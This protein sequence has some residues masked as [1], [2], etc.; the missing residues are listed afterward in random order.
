MTADFTLYLDGSTILLRPENATA[1]KHVEE[2]VAEYG[3]WLVRFYVKDGSS[4]LLRKE[5]EDAFFVKPGC[6]LATLADTLVKRGFTVVK[7]DKVKK[8]EPPANADFL[9][10]YEG[11]KVL[12]R[13]QNSRARDHLETTLTGDAA[14]WITALWL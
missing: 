2:N 7:E 14:R 4:F 12:V 9:V 13:P 11:S 8:A 1:R 3:Q 6:V 5:K 10:Y